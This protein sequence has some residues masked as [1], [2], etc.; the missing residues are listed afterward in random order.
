MPP[1]PF[2]LALAAGHEIELLDLTGFDSLAEAPAERELSAVP[3]DGSDEASRPEALPVIPESPTPPTL[4]R[5]SGDASCGYGCPSTPVSPFTA[6]GPD[7]GEAGNHIE[8]PIVIDDLDGEEGGGSRTTSIVAMSV[9][10]S[11]RVDLPRTPSPA[12]D[13]GC[14]GTFIKSEP[15][16]SPAPPPPPRKPSFPRVVVEVPLIRE[17][18]PEGASGSP[19]AR[20]QAIKPRSDLARRGREL[21]VDRASTDGGGG[22]EDEDDDDDYTNDKGDEDD[23]DDCQPP[24]GS[25][26]RQRSHA[27]DVAGVD[28]ATRPSNR[29]VLENDMYTFAST[30]ATCIVK[31]LSAPHFA[32]GN[33]DTAGAGGVGYNKFA[34]GHRGKRGRWSKKEDELLLSLVQKDSPP[35]EDDVEE[36]FPLRTL[37][38]RALSPT[39]VPS[40]VGP[41]AA[42]ERAAE[43]PQPRSSTPTA[44]LKLAPG[45]VKASKA[46]TAVAT[47]DTMAGTSLRNL[48]LEILAPISEELPDLYSFCSAVQV[49]APPDTWDDLTRI[50]RL[51]FSRTCRE[52]AE[53][54]KYGMIVR[55]LLSAVY[56][57]KFGGNTGRGLLQEGWSVLKQRGLEELLIPVGMAVARRL[58]L[59]ERGLLYPVAFSHNSHMPR[60][61]AN[62]CRH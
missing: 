61:A 41:P 10:P 18:T 31:L 11:E 14:D 17:L 12:V 9:P 23:E 50:A 28:A 19:R 62:A 5:R 49:L 45:P 29:R 32:Q 59:W 26:K 56:D 4:D 24:V 27:P 40:M 36:L 46:A 54:H 2:N 16:P 20:L 42:E 6:A 34:V 51:S 38:S 48:P 7:R 52:V 15:S 30:V 25:L 8:D 13:D 33:D 47:T 58:P 39:R 57:D 55:G 1:N 3:S 44:S 53:H 60:Q 43:N 37:S 22:G 21:E 35:T